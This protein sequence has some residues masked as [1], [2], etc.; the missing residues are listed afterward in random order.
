MKETVK[1]GENGKGSQK[2]KIELKA[3]ICH[4]RFLVLLNEARLLF[5]GEARRKQQQ[6]NAASRV[7]LCMNM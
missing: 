2:W 5:N 1:L 3:I 6:C 7:L 4:G